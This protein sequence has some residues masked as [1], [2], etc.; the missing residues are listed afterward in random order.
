[1]EDSELLDRLSVPGRPALFSYEIAG[2]KRVTSNTF[3]RGSSANYHPNR[4]DML[5]SSSIPEYILAGWMPQ[6]PFIEGSS[7]L[8]AFGSCFAKNIGRYL[9]GIGYNV[10]TKGKGSTYVQAI[11]DG[12]VNVHA[13][14]QQFEWAWENRKPT[15]ELWHGWKAEEYGYDEDIRVAT[16]KLFDEADVFILTFGLSEV[17]FDSHTGEVFWRA[18]PLDK[19]DS[20]RHGFKCV[21]F[22]ETY[23]R[24]RRI[25]DL[26][27]KYNP[28]S[29]IVFTLSPIPINATFRP[30]SCITA[31]AASKAT[32]R[33]AI[34]QL[35]D[36]VHQDDSSFYYFPAYE[37]VNNG[38]VNGLGSD[39]R[40]PSLH[41]VNYSMSAFERYFCRTGMT[42]ER[43]GA[44][45]DEAIRMDSGLDPAQFDEIRRRLE[46]QKPLSI[47]R[48]VAVLKSERSREE[49]RQAV[50]MARE[51][52]RKERLASQDE[53]RRPS[54][55]GQDTSVS[56]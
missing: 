29:T 46:E 14:C 37:I 15:V 38:F 2:E 42:D 7:K 45:L 56:E 11:G 50:E 48:E 54:S 12:M 8:V 28:S 19:Y 3:Y 21:R 34:D 27:R 33:S 51:A 13:I 52:K 31:N 22:A 40:H 23:E 55:H 25:Y 41:A 53:R 36:E 16:K 9:A 26:I 49:R 39:M 20:A 47:D 32:L 35:Y 6:E 44:I 1:M 4:A 18:V 24:L 30:V 43:L 17:W 5:H 10:T